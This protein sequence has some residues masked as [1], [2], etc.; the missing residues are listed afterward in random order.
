MPPPTSPLISAKAQARTYPDVVLP[1]EDAQEH[2]FDRSTT[3]I[4]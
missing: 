1:F 4:W 2:S 3:A